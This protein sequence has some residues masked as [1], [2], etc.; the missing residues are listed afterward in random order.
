MLHELM[1]R[2]I[3]DELNAIPQTEALFEQKRITS[4][5][6]RRWWHQMLLDGDA[7]REDQRDPEGYAIS[8]DWLYENYVKALDEAGGS[9]KSP[10]GLQTE[11]GMF[12]TKMLPAGYPRH[13]RFG[14]GGPRAW[15]LPSLGTCREHYEKQYGMVGRIAWPRSAE[16][17]TQGAVLPF[18]QRREPGEDDPLA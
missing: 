3:G 4:S 18:P 7:W 2:T 14:H 17:G 10:K 15:V 8:R 11:L 13:K 6:Q 5:P 12:L 16:D 1:N 9:W